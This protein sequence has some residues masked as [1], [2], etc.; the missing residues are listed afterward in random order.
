MGGPSI[1]S[2]DPLNIDFSG[3]IGGGVVGGGIGISPSELLEGEIVMTIV[4]G[5]IVYQR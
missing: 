5:T 4:A 1:L 2:I 3:D